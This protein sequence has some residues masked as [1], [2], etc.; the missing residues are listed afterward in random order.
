[1]FVSTN[2]LIPYR[3]NPHNEEKLKRL[4]VS[5]CEWDARL[6]MD[7]S[8]SL[9]TLVLNCVTGQCI[10]VE[11]NNRHEAFKR[12]KRE[13]FPVHVRVEDF[14]KDFPSGGKRVEDIP[15]KW[16]PLDAPKW[17]RK[18]LWED[19]AFEVLEEVFQIKVLNLFLYISLF[20]KLGLF[21]FFSFVLVRQHCH[22][23][24]SVDKVPTAKADIS[25]ELP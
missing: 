13:W 19:Y 8:R 16:T 17:M 6:Y 12:L 24:F 9:P 18:R 4:T 10:L 2:D 15:S 21:T 1:M 7:D 22:T 11:G 20:I 14:E 3:G 5:L 23:P 25:F